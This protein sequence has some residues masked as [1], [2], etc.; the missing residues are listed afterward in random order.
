MFNTSEGAENYTFLQAAERMRQI[1]KSV[2]PPTPKNLQHFNNLLQMD[3]NKHFTMSFQKQPNLYIPTLIYW[4]TY[5]RFY[6][7]SIIVDGLFVGV[8]FCNKH[9][10]ETIQNE[11]HNVTISGCDGTF[12]TVPKTLDDDCYQLFTFQVIHRNT[13]FPMVYAI[14]TGKTEEIYV[15]LFK[16][17]RNVLPLRYDKLT[18]ITDFELGLINAI[19]LVFPES[20]HQGCYFHYC[21]SILRHLRSKESRMYNLAKANPIAARIFRMVLALPYLPPNL[22]N[23]RI[24]SMLD[25]F[26]SIIMYIVQ[27]TEI[28]EYFHDFMYQYVFGY[29]FV[30]MRPKAFTV[31]DKDIRTNNYL[32]SYHAALLRFIKPRPKILGIHGLLVYVY[33]HI[34]Q[35]R[36]LENQYNLEF[37]QVSQNLNIRSCNS[38]RGRIRNRNTSE[39]KRFMQD[40]IEDDAPDRI[41][42]FL[43]RAGHQRSN[44]QKNFSEKKGI[45]KCI[46][47][48]HDIF[49]EQRRQTNNILKSKKRLYEKRKIEVIEKNRCSAKKFFKESGSIKAGFKP[50][51]RI[52]SDELG[53]SNHRREANSVPF[54]RIF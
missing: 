30:R 18:I 4:V 33:V 29:W 6:Q 46:P 35:I 44:K 8:Q 47:G 38:S 16:Y 11:L 28:T 14:L 39:I 42:T 21:Q 50:Q 53:K 25:G 37:K 52:L 1:R 10:I 48:K 22:N 31:F 5:P 54:Q 26:N 2:F 7:G 12:K 23:N 40:L 19:R 20:S 13:S 32:E 36:F 51:T 17:A 15:G 49:E 9:H 34:C 41:L 27:H 3:S 43:R 24:P 45:T